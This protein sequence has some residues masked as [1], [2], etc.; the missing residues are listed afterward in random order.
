MR[1][2]EGLT[3]ESTTAARKQIID[4]FLLSSFTSA[5][6]QFLY[7][8][9]VGTF[10]FNSFLAGIF[11]SAGFFVLTVCLRMQVN[12]SNP[13][14]KDVSDESAFF[15]YVLSNVLLNLVVFNFIG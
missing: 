5:I 11:S 6:V 13:E 7:M 3:P 15:D 4:A 12:P 10:P 1:R 9:I 2:R 8:M 14:F